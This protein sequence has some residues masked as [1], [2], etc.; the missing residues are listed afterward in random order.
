MLLLHRIAYAL[1]FTWVVLRL[2]LALTT[3]PYVWHRKV[4]GTVSLRAGIDNNK[5]FGRLCAIKVPTLPSR[6]NYAITD[7]FRTLQNIESFTIYVTG[8]CD[9][10]DSKIHISSVTVRFKS[11]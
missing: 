8:V 1:G 10:F 5:L 11:G 9:N 4:P 2:H 6:R 7:I 3:V